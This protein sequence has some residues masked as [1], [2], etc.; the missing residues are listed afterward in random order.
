MMN[1]IRAAMLVFLICFSCLFMASLVYSVRDTLQGGSLRLDV[2]IFLNSLLWCSSIMAAALLISTSPLGD[3]IVTLF[4]ATRK[5]SLREEEQINPA[6]ERIK[7]LYL[8]KQGVD[9]DINVC[10]MD[11]PHINGMA[12]G[13][14]TAAI[15]TGMLKVG[16][17]DEIVGILAHEAGH[18][19]HKDSVFSLALLVAELPTLLL[20]YIFRFIFFFG[21]T[22]NL[23]PSSGQ[24]F[25]WVARM[26]ILVMFFILFVHFILFWVLSFPVLWLMRVF[27]IS[28]Q[29]NVEYRADKFALDIGYGPAL[30]EL[31]E[32]IE[33]EDIRNSTGFLSKYLYSHPPTALRIDKL[34]RNLKGE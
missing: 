11:Q 29:W 22:P 2:P 26:F 34:E 3:R 17:D 19:H 25:G 30:I 18:L 28:T 27:E 20:N 10:V 15:S 13:R 23:L 14:Q 12:L 5:Q 31:F 8:Q 21:P 24:D 9:L 7:D 6:I 4:F 1:F 33:D 32:R 16:S